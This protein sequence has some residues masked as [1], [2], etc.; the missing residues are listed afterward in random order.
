MYVVTPK[1]VV[2]AIELS[3]KIILIQPKVS[4]SDKDR[5]YIF[6]WL[7]IYKKSSFFIVLQLGANQLEV[8]T[9]F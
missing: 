1:N 7:D 2:G 9:V 4:Q 5:S 3:K 6:L 8:S